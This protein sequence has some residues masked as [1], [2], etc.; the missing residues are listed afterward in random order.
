MR[1]TVGAFLQLA[2]GLVSAAASASSPDPDVVED[3]DL[4]AAKGATAP[5]GPAATPTPTP[6]P[7]APLAAELARLDAG[8]FARLAAE[9]WPEESPPDP[10]RT[11]SLYKLQLFL[12][13][14][15]ARGKHF[16]LALSGQLNQ[17]WAHDAHGFRGSFEALL[18][19]A[20]VGLY[21]SALDLRV[22]QQRLAWGNTEFLSPND[23]LNARDWRD[24]FVGPTELRFLPTP[25]ARVDAECGAWSAQ[26]A[27]SPVFVPDRYDVYGTNWAAVQP[28]AGPAI[29]Q[30]A[31]QTVGMF[32]RSVFDPAQRLFQQTRL[33]SA[34]FGQPS[35]GARL[36][37]SGNR[38]ELHLY[39]HLG[40]AGP[41]VA[42]GPVPGTLDVSYV[43]R[44]H[45]GLDWS[46]LL[47]PFAWRLDAAYQ[48]RE[49]FFRD[50]FLTHESRVLKL[51]GAI[52][53]QTGD[54]AKV[55]LIEAYYQHLF[56]PY[57]GTLLFWRSTSVGVGV[58]ARWPLFAGLRAE[59]RAPLGIR[60]RNGV[61]RGELVWQQG[62]W[63]VSLGGL[64]IA[65][66]NRSFGWYYANNDQLYTALR[67]DF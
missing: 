21:S 14:R 56:D 47:G 3:I 28:A 41:K 49:E 42:L 35:F 66:E 8:G 37:W 54:T 33:P 45:V 24:P 2:F 44:H 6:T 65:G 46:A 13:G 64:L 59:L 25:M 57:P 19:D 7:V 20:Y 43:R 40:Y 55:L 4:D 67:T 50:D 53:Y 48:S 62:N 36:G 30:L 27:V 1:G 12:R 58:L 22:G 31:A 10:G 52:E 9:Y 18:R 32:D 60:P 39:Y 51:A 11:D 17:S 34:D 15:Y 5:P 61:A 16:E 26:L 23:V 63:S 38:L 29:N